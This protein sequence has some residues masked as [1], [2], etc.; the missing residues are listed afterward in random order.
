MFRSEAMKY[1]E[2][3]AP[4]E[5]AWEMMNYLG[6]AECV[7]FVDEDPD[8]PLINRPY[9]KDIRRC[10]E[11]EQKLSAILRFM[12]KFNVSR[13]PLD[14]TVEYKEIL[15]RISANL[16]THQQ[17][18]SNYFDKI[19]TEVDEKH[20]KITEAINNYEK[21]V[22]EF[23]VLKLNKIVLH[24]TLKMFGADFN[25]KSLH[26]DEEVGEVLTGSAAKFSYVAGVIKTEELQRFKRMLF[27]TTRG[28]IYMKF[29]EMTMTDHGIDEGLSIFFLIFQSGDG[30]VLRLKIGRICESFEAIK[31]FFLFLSF[32]IK[33]AKTQ[34]NRFSI[35]DNPKLFNEKQQE[36]IK[37]LSQTELINQSSREGILSDL[38]EFSHVRED[39]ICSYID[40]MRIFVLREKLIKTHFNMMNEGMSF[41]H[42][43]IWVTE[44]DVEALKATI[45]ELNTKQ[46]QANGPKIQLNE[47]N[48]RE[49][50]KTPPT[51][52]KTNEFTDLFQVLFASSPAY[53]GLY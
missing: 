6:R 4:Y 21:L 30:N 1:F 53:K 2:I 48:F 40:E 24:S 8:V 52:F 45:S 5:S 34:K 19:E 28:N 20:G 27:R 18:E 23:R 29:E 39:M 49:L 35:P 31:Y 32:Q 12:Q 36:I 46:V 25:Y 44:T 47:L 16:K 33:V 22:E 41:L 50:K 51:R 7:H 26:D 37:R 38:R 13:K 9:A 3:V 43:K 42:S 14:P 17:A 11:L 10:D 15:T